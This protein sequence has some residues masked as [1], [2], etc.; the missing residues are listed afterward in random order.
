MKQPLLGIVSTVLVCAISLAL[1]SLFDFPTFSGWVSYFLLCVIP[2]QIVMLAL[3]RTQRPHFAAAHGQPAKGIFLTLLA[4]VW[5]GVVAAMYFVTIGGSV[6]PPTPMLT[7]C[8]I[9]TVPITFW[10]CIVWGGWPSTILIKNPIGAG[11]AQL[12]AGYI[13]NY[14]L[15]RVFF[16][17]E[18]M[19]GAPVYVASL[20]PHGFFNAWK[21][22]P[23]YISVLA[24]MFLVIDFDLWPLTKFPRLMKQPALGLVWMLTI[25]AIGGM[26]FYIGV[27]VMAMDPVMYLTRVPV[28]YLFGSIV[29]LNM[30]QNSLFGKLPQPT[31]GI[32]NALATI[33]FGVGLSWIFQALMPVV[34]GRLAS[35]PPPYDAEIWLASALLSVTFPFLVFYS[36]FWDFWPLKKQ[37]IRG[38]VTNSPN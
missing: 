27:E 32:L 13:L 5:G 3:W 17:Y 30:F 33:C 15:F 20:D 6:G 24:A 12:T 34:T 35:G 8:T 28:P 29:V 9:V 16:S 18:F 31:K 19:Q 22:L 2:M 10:L 1:I 25:L 14:L 21:A 26:A 4:M 11:L 36:D 37:E 38:Q 7:M 23:F